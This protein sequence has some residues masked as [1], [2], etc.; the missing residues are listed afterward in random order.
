[1]NRTHFFTLA[2]AFSLVTA[3]T[4]CGSEVQSEPVSSKPKVESIPVEVAAVVHGAI[5]ASYASTATLEAEHEAKIVAEVSGIV[6]DILVEEGDHVRQGQV[7]ARLDAERSRLQ[8][9]QAEGEVQR[10]KND[11]TRNERLMS[12]QLIGRQAFEQ[13]QYDYATRKAEVDLTKVIL[14]KSDIVAPF[15][16]VVTHRLIKQGQLL[17][18]HDDAFQVANFQELTAKLHV[19]ERA[20]AAIRTNQPVTFTVDAYPE[21]T[22][23]ANVERVAPVVDAASGTVTVSVAIKNRDGRLRPGL[24]TR[25]SIVYDHIVDAPLVPKAAVMTDQGQSSVFIV[26]AGKVHRVK[27][28]LGYESGAS[29]Q[30]LNGVTSG[31]IVVVAGQN[32]LSE[33]AAVEVVQ[34]SE[35]VAVVNEPGRG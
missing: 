23:T 27:L 15:D 30:V 7:L 1:M 32:A 16:G 6:L 31:Q 11:I 35:A 22:Y 26:D 2:L 29:V 17:N 9:R 14:R 20:A 33:D 18:V 34:R 24:F 12:R 21:Q 19:P 4:G 13:S 10:L 5:D 28:K 25:Q 8:V 3:L